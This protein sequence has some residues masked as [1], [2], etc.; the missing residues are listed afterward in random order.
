MDPKILK[1]WPIYKSPPKFRSFGRPWLKTFTPSHDSVD[2][3][4][5]A[6]YI[7][8]CFCYK[9]CASRWLPYT[10]QC[11][12]IKT[13]IKEIALLFISIVLQAGSLTQANVD[14]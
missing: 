9:Y 3:Y 12:Y 8:N 1:H 13:N 10:S 11:G 14:T 7:Y 6:Q 5:Q 4:K 2:T